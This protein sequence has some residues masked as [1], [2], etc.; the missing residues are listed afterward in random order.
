[1]IFTNFRYLLLIIFLFSIVFQ[2]L[3]Y[4][5][6]A[7]NK[8]RISGI[9]LIKI[10]IRSI[11]FLLF[12]L[13]SK[14]LLTRSL[15]NQRI[16]QK[17]LFVIKT[18]NSTGFNLTE[19][20]QINIITRVPPTKFK[21]LEICLLNTSD[22]QF[23]QFIPPTSENTF[24]HVLK[25]ERPFSRVLRKITMPQMQSFQQSKRIEVYENQK[26]QWVLSDTNQE[27]FNLFEFLNEENAYLSPY[28][29]HYLLILI[30]CLLSLDIGIK[31]RILKI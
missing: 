1:M 4:I 18:K 12:I 27:D 5:R 3:R 20:D 10:L 17:A 28:L 23:Y 2:Y 24:L 31:Y 7:K 11:I 16:N 25:I 8:F 30:L 21:Q 22:H 9:L 29:L 19:D 26:N 13:A 15:T 6:I 14:A